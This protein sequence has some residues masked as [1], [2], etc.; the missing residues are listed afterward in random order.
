MTQRVREIMTP[1]PVTLTERAPIRE[2]ARLMRERG[3][4]EV[5]VVDA[6]RV[7][8]VVTDRDLTVRA[9]A[10]ERNP[11]LT[12]VGQVCSRE[13]VTCAPG[14]TV[15]DTVRLM[16]EHALRR[17]PVVDGGRLVGTLTLGD[18]AVAQDPDSALA[19]I[20][21]ARPNR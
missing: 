18:V 15:D 14:D 5:V 2:A 12:T 13:L 19:G 16:R 9:M 17:L 3:I 10:D 7:R 6:E 8:G 4:G 1:H 21:R 20:T 11:S